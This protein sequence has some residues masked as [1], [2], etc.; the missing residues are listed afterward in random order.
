MKRI[1]IA[2]LLLAMV[3]TAC[4]QAPDANLVIGKNLDLYSNILQEQRKIM[5]YLPSS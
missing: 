3:F 4:G 5:V 1:L 2:P